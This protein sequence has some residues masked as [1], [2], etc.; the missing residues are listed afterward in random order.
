[1]TILNI[2][3]YLLAHGGKQSAKMYTYKHQKLLYLLCPWFSDPARSLNIVSLIVD[4]LSTLRLK[5]SQ[6]LQESGGLKIWM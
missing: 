6:F 1:M 5:L 4:R 3:L 2:M